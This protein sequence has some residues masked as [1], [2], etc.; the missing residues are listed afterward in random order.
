MG[1]TLQTHA[2]VLIR[3]GRCELE[4]VQHLFFYYCVVAKQLWFN[5][6]QV[7]DRNVGNDFLSIGQMW[8]SNSRFL[9]DNIFL[10]CSPVGALK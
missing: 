1:Q 2:N 7:M 6:S 9:V 3:S 10:C 5:I 4:S 8:L